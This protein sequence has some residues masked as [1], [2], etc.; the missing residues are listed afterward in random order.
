MII[1]LMGVSGSGKT[2]VGKLL[3]QNLGWQFFDGDDYHPQ[4]NIRKMQQGFPLE[5]QD[6]WP[7]LDVLNK[8]MTGILE[9]DKSAVI[10]CSAL[11]KAYRDRLGRNL[12]QVKFVYLRGSYHLIMQRMQKRQG[13]YFQADLLASQFEILEVSKDIHQIDI[14][15]KPEA[16]VANVRAVVGL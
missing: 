14:F 2:T 6:R 16:I 4:S 11:K 1:I 12:L 7:W 13:H 3:A 9:N 5:D 10:A 15:H 8:L